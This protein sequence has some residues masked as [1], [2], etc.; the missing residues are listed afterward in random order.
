MTKQEVYSQ[1][2]G[3]AVGAPGHHRYFLHN[4]AAAASIV[5]MYRFGRDR[6]I[7][8]LLEREYPAGSGKNI[9][10]NII[11][12]RIYLADGNRHATALLLLAPEITFGELEQL[13]PGL[14]RIW[15]AGVEEGCNSAANPYDVYIPADI[16]IGRVS[17]AYLGTDYFRNPPAPTN[18]VPAD[19]P[20]DSERLSPEDRGRPLYQTALALLLH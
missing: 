11:A 18:I 17:G 12:G 5:E 2:L 8:A 15:F 19:F 10:L 9:I 14:L 4:S 6:G 7:K 20:A 16:D 13:R 1:A 3:G